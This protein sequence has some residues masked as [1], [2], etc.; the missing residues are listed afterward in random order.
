M[1][2]MMNMKKLLPLFVVAF[3]ASAPVLAQNAA[4]VNGKA[5]SKAKLD[6]LVKL[7]GKPDSAELR[8]RIRTGLIEGEL[9]LQ[10]AEKLGLAKQTAVKEQ[11]EQA[12]RSVLFAAVFENYTKQHGPTDAE[13][14]AEYEKIKAALV[15]TK[16]Y[17]ARHILL[18]KEA[19]ALNVIAKLKAGSKFEDL[20]KEMSKDTGSA[21]NGG[22]LG[23]VSPGALL[24][25]FSQTMVAVKKGEYSTV[26][27]KTQFGW[28]VIKLEDVRDRQIPPMDQVKSELVRAVL[29]DQN[30]QREKIQAMIKGLVSK[31][32]IQ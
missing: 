26:P 23:W 17:H 16:E 15:G 27:T 28:H 13:L 9:V 1:T 7:S 11:L 3:I 12:R 29:S 10:E 8:D 22:D 18:E 4:T 24:P 30:W 6:E 19:D 31:A 5:I 2:D 21:A 32:K 20:A 14:K 25:E